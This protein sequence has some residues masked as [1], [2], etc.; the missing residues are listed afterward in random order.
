MC[1]PV[2]YIPES[3]CSGFSRHWQVAQ[4]HEIM[5]RDECRQDAQTP[6]EC[7]HKIF[8]MPDRMEQGYGYSRTLKV[9]R[10]RNALT[11]AVVLCECGTSPLVVG[12]RLV[13]EPRCRQ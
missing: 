12:K 3:V 10:M 13:E 1:D 2:A 9:D 7:D 4:S 8:H 11:N 6:V 5:R